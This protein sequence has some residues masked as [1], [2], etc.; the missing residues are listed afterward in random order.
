MF[1]FMAEQ[2]Q[3]EDVLIYKRKTRL[4]V[5]DEFV[6]DFRNKL[7]FDEVLKRRR[8]EIQS[9]IRDDQP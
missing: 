9:K 2:P 3:T 1:R 8:T 6:Y 5:E 4:S 7:N